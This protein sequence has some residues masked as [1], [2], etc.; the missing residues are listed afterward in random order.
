MARSDLLISLVKSG[1]ESPDPRFRQAAEALIAEE[2]A[3]RHYVLADEI[4]TA[5]NARPNGQ[6]TGTINYSSLA[7]LIYESNPERSLQDLVLPSSAV[8]QLRELIEE[9]HRAEL[10][11]SYGLAPRHRVLLVG[12]P[13]NGK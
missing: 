9:Q 5:L 4:S 12:P 13:G 7:D 6:P 1:K 2:R 8:R 10:L 3:K 11:N